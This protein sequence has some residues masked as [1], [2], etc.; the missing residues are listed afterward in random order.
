[1][2]NTPVLHHNRGVKALRYTVRV[3]REI[4]LVYT[5]PV[6]RIVECTKTGSQ[7]LMT[8]GICQTASRLGRIKLVEYTG[9]WPRCALLWA[10]L[11]EI[12]AEVRHGR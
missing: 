3:N 6:N 10:R 11:K 5:K 9:K 2:S 7:W 8:K 1:M 12:V 4:K